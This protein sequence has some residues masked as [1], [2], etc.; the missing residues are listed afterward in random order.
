MC[1][2]YDVDSSLFAVAKG[3]APPAPV[4]TQQ[5]AGAPGQPPAQ[6]QVQPQQRQQPGAPQQQ[7]QQQQ[8]QQ[9]QKGPASAPKVIDP[10]KP[11]IVQ[12]GKPAQFSAK[13]SG[14]PGRL[15]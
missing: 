3:G 8:Q 9:Q 5:R 10:I 1:H 7:P 14:V 2:L 11:L 15:T 6:V 13:I 4:P 12:E